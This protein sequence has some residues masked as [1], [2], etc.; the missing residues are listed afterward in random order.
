LD[1]K[2]RLDNIQEKSKETVGQ[3]P[4]SKR[5][6]FLSFLI[7]LAA[8][9]VFRSSLDLPQTED[10]LNTQTDSTVLESLS[11]I[12]TENLW[13][14]K[15]SNWLAYSGFGLVFSGIYRALGDALLWNEPKET[16]TELEDESFDF[17][18]SGTITWFTNWLSTSFMKC[19][20]AAL[21]TCPMWLLAAWLARRKVSRETKVGKSSSILGYCGK[22]GGPFY[23][24]IYGPLK[25]NRSVSGT[26][27]S[28]PGLACPALSSEEDAE[29]HQLISLLKK[30]K[31]LNQTNL[32]LVRVI[33]AHKN[34]PA[35][36]LEERSAEEEDA[37]EI[38]AFVSSAEFNLE[39]SS[40][41]GLQAVLIAHSKIKSV[42]NQLSDE[43]SPKKPISFEKYSSSISQL[44][45]DD[46]SLIKS[47][48]NCLSPTKAKAL[49]STP[50]TV[51]ATAYLATEAGKALVY[52]P[53]EDLFSRISVFPHLQARAVLQSLQSYHSNY[54][55]DGRMIIRQSILCS[56]RH[57]DF[58]RAFLPVSMPIQA[59]GLRDWLEILYTPKSDRDGRAEL[60]ALDSHLEALHNNLRDR[61]S[62]SESS[63]ENLLE[64]VPY[65]SVVLVP[66]EKLIDFNFEN[67]EKALLSRIVELL[68]HTRELQENLS[69]SARLPGF[70]RQ[71]IE[72]AKCKSQVGEILEELKARKGGEKLI[73]KWTI[74]RR[75]LTR[76]N[77][78]STRV[79][80]EGV[81][82]DGLIQAKIAGE[83]Y[84]A[85]VPLRQR[86]FDEVLGNN[87]ESEYFPNSINP[88]DVRVFNT[89]AEFKKVSGG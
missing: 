45:S 75:T 61:L 88:R 11:P 14:K 38:G 82:E 39:Q 15:R 34:Y 56:R 4:G 29:N 42:Q 8:S 2:R 81:P 13:S 21:L 40:I 53:M 25:P 6:I 51:V 80:D 26:D 30:F 35:E 69:I 76:Y 74:L 73:E 24:G 44:I 32:D 49:A 48:A 63:S 23:S 31:A 62:K 19:L 7:L 57:G 50:P 84:N 60:V 59:R 54:K 9:Y 55:G 18:F 12:E 85:L 17:S 89:L 78:L 27:Y 28:C 20:F 72:A 67:I 70:K 71:A 87:W 37:E 10:S 65:K 79:G 36:V 47:L 22:P 1:F 43:D 64:G 46:S 3:A 52:E 5:Y 58:G 83:P 68:D 77:W 66:L 33:L 16:E 41:E 86:R